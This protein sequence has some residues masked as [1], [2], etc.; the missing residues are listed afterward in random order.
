M[1]LNTLIIS[2][3]II[4]SQLLKRHYFK[5]RS[6][7]NYCTGPKTNQEPIFFCCRTK[8]YFYVWLLAV[9]A[10]TVFWL[11]K[12]KLRVLFR[13]PRGYFWWKRSRG[14]ASVP[15]KVLVH[16]R[17]IPSGDESYVI[18]SKSSSLYYVQY[19]CDYEISSYSAH[20]HTCLCYMHAGLHASTYVCVLAMLVCSGAY[21][22]QQSVHVYI[23]DMY[24]GAYSGVIY[25]CGRFLCV[26]EKSEHAA[27]CS[28]Y[29]DSGHG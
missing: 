14:H 21:M 18:A 26:V 22:L 17:K 1:S 16:D 9:W 23:T 24:G 5:K 27:T 28:K 11:S 13:G 29:P 2:N 4:S 7:V 12:N 25:K 20:M 15:L 6:E 8:K 19:R 10:S 3:K